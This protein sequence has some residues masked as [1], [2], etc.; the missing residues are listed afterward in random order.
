M[1]G[2]QMI[3][4]FS[5][6]ELESQRQFIEDF[7]VASPDFQDKFG[8]AD[9]KY[10]ADMLTLASKFIGHTYRCL[11]LTLEMPFKDNANLPDAAVGWDGA[12]SA[13]LGEAILQPVLR[14][15]TR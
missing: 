2:N 7:K 12:R 10:S 4:G 14:A 3:E 15:L 9:N 13:R 8:Y 6:A 11:S 5:A 1:A